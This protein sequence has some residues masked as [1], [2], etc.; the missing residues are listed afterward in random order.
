MVE[1]NILIKKVKEGA[2]I[3]SKIEQGDWIDIKLPEDVTLEPGEFKKIE[4][5]LAMQIP[6]GY[7]AQLVMRSS[8]YERYQLLQ[9]NAIGIIDETY[10]GNE[11][12]WLLPVLYMGDEEITIEAGTRL[13]QFRIVRN[14]PKVNFLETKDLENESRGGF[15]STGK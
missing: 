6:Y 13:C 15:G 14:Q 11:D 10:N 2:N 5:G 3:P 9:T 8:T 4:L 1:K 12:E 7:E